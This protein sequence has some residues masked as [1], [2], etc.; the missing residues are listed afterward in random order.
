[1][2]DFPEFLETFSFFLSKL[3]KDRI[4]AIKTETFIY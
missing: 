3:D 4:I 2:E 1:M